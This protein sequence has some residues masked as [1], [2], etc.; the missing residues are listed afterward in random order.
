MRSSKAK[1]TQAREA[2]WIAA[3]DR[4]KLW[5]YASDLEPLRAKTPQYGAQ[6]CRH[7][8]LGYAVLIQEKDI[9]RADATCEFDTGI[10]GSGKPFVRF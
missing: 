9:R 6:T 7:S 2:G 5:S 4:T 1:P 10:L 8:R 3:C